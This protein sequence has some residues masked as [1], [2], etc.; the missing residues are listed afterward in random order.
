FLRVEQT[1][2]VYSRHAIARQRLQLQTL[3][4]L[5]RQFAYDLSQRMT[6]VDLVIAEAQDDEHLQHR[7]AA[8]DELQQVECGMIRPVNVLQY[9]D[10]DAAFVPD[11]VQ[12]AGKNIGGPG[13][14]RHDRPQTRAKRG[15]HI[16]QRAK[17][18]WRKQRIAA[19]PGDG[20]LPG[21]AP[22]EFI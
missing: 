9:E 2:G 21:R 5:V 10:E 20:E 22:A 16:V 7:D 14:R 17:R 6:L 15:S 11:G 1:L 4:M 12:H 3:D 13:I 8:T 19:S 18:T